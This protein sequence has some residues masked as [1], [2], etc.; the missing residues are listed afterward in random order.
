MDEEHN[1]R[2]CAE[3]VLKKNNARNAGFSVAVQCKGASS[4]QEYVA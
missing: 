3:K 1:L 4:S 2:V